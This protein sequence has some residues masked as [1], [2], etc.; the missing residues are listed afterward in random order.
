[1]NNQELAKTFFGSIKG[2]FYTITDG[3]SELT[4]ENIKKIISNW[5]SEGYHLNY[6]ACSALSHQLYAFGFKEELYKHS[7][8]VTKAF[9]HLRKI[10]SYLTILVSD[11]ETYSVLNH[12]C[13]EDVFFRM[14]KVMRLLFAR[15]E[16]IED[17]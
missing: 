10:Q 4:S 2:C 5:K 11:R 9:S 1:M 12:Y 8:D 14:W 16:R 15:I 6:S 13:D 17:K 7:K 3:E